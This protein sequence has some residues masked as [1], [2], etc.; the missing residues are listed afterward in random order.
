MFMLASISFLFKVYV[1]NSPHRIVR[2]CHINVKPV[3]P[4][5]NDRKVLKGG[6]FF[7]EQKVDDLSV[8]ASEFS[9]SG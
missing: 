5:R 4:N 1:H 7:L 8:F 9:D 3:I 6:E 2:S